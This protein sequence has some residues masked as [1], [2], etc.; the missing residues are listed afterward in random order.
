MD[1]KQ[2]ATF[3]KMYLERFKKYYKYKTIDRKQLKKNIFDNPKLLDKQKED[4]WKLIGGDSCEDK[5][6]R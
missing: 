5:R 6:V 3:K 4:F 1:K 2:Y